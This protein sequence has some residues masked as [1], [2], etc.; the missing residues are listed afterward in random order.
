MTAAEAKLGACQ[1]LR[2]GAPPNGGEGFGTGAHARV[3]GWDACS[4]ALI[5]PRVNY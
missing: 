4:T 5:L 2:G 3:G 1:G